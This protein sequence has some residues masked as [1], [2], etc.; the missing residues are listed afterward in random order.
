[1]VLQLIRE[2]MSGLA[3]EGK[4]FIDGVF[5]CHTLEDTDRHLENGGKKIYGQTA[6]PRGI[7]DMDITYSNRFKKEMPIILN[8]P[9]FEGIR[10][11]SGNYAGQETFLKAI[12]INK[13][14]QTLHTLEYVEVV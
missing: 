10:I 4:L 12:P 13:E 2:N 7:Y 3:T 8:V 11:H 9:F 1:M 5:E 14:K 6:I